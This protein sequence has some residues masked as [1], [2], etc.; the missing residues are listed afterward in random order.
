MWRLAVVTIVVG[1]GCQSVYAPFMGDGGPIQGATTVIGGM[2]NPDLAVIPDGGATMLPAGAVR[3]R[4]ST[5]SRI[6]A[7]FD[8]CPSSAVAGCRLRTCVSADLAAGGVRPN[9]GNL[10]VMSPSSDH[11]VSPQGDGTYLP[12]TVVGPLWSAAGAMVT[13]SGSGADYAAFTVTLAGPTSVTVTN[14]LA[15]SLD[16][17]RSADLTVT[18]TDGTAGRVT[19]EI[20]NATQDLECDFAVAADSGLVPRQA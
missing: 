9:I 19:V 11:T 12:L 7:D 1:G 8:L 18:W 20:S 16:V 2:T 6:S 13:L 17:P 15:G 4:S 14:P 10:R 5:Q 3:A